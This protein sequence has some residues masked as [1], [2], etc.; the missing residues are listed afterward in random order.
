MSVFASILWVIW[1]VNRE[2]PTDLSY[3]PAASQSTGNPPGSIHP[4]GAF[5][6]RTWCR[7]A[8]LLSTSCWYAKSCCRSNSSRG[9]TGASG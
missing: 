8:G 5:Q 6:K 2:K 4:S 9:L 3:V 1:K 7:F